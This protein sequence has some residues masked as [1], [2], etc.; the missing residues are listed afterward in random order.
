MHTS[1]VLT[2]HTQASQVGER[3]YTADAGFNISFTDS[4]DPR[5]QPYDHY[6]Q[7][8]ITVAENWL[9]AA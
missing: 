2:G 3:K 8:G 7:V 1:Q 5:T 9:A 4:P 6:F